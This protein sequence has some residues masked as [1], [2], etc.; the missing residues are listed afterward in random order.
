MRID[1]IVVTRDEII[2]EYIGLR[3]AASIPRESRQKNFP[4]HAIVNVASFF[5]SDIDKISEFHTY[6]SRLKHTADFIIMLYEYKL[7]KYL[8]LY[9]DCLFKTSY[10]TR[11]EMNMH[12][13]MS[14]MLSRTAK[15]FNIFYRYFSDQKFTKIMLLPLRNFEAP[16]LVRLRGL[17]RAGITSVTFPKDLEDR[18]SELR[19]RQTPKKFSTYQTVYLRDDGGRY[20]SYGNE[21]HSQVES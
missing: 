11:S 8:G 20:F 1:I 17:F 13:Y 14:M 18:L 21:R 15:Y 2:H 9:F 12:N 4:S 3:K 10:E 5:Y 19:K 6:I 16:E 7:Q